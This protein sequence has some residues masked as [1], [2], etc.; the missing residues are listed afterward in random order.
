MYLSLGST[1]LDSRSVRGPGGWL[2]GTHRRAQHLSQAFGAPHEVRVVA[3]VGQRVV[4]CE[5][6]RRSP[7]ARTV[8][9]RAAWVVHAVAC[10]VA[11]ASALDVLGCVQEVHEVRVQAVG[12]NASV[13]GEPVEGAS[14]A[15]QILPLH[16]LGSEAQAPQRQHVLN[17][18][19]L[20]TVPRRPLYPRLRLRIGLGQLGICH[21][22]HGC[23][24]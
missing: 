16:E 5:H 12:H 14:V 22:R 23:L 13:G 20:T 3:G 4:V 2:A 9:V 17:D 8:T 7:H 6:Y 1:G 18:G 10:R 24:S 19:R 15:A 21:R 11:V